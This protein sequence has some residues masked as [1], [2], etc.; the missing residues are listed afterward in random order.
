[1]PE[2]SDKGILQGTK[3][4]VVKLMCGLQFKDRKRSKDSMLSLNETMDQFAMANRALDF[5]V[6]GQRKYGMLK[7]T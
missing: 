6:E 1:M 4:S 5:E 3:R 7:R 2:E